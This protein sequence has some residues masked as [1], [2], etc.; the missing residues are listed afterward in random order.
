MPQRDNAEI[1]A[2]AEK[3]LQATLSLFETKV[4]QVQF[5]EEFR[6]RV[7]MDDWD[8]IARLVEQRP[9][10]VVGIQEFIEGREFINMRGVLYP[11]VMQEIIRLN[12]GS[13]VEAVLTG[14]IGTGKTTIALITTA[15]QL[16]LLA[17]YDNPQLK[18]GLDPSSEIVFIFQSITAQLAK[19][20]DY[21][22]FKAMIDNSPWFQENFR[23]DKQ[24]L[25]EL[26]FPNRI[27]CKPVSGADTAAIGQNVFGGVIDELNFMAV[28]DG[29][30]H[31]RDGGTYDQAVAVYNSISRRRKSRFMTMGKLPGI[32]NL[33]SSVRYPGQF[34]DTK[35]AESYTDI[36]RHGTTSLFV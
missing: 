3:H 27:I 29:S 30:K 31:S 20:V 35:I 9:E 12:N 34:T 5:L 17:Q 25:S 15:Y 1:L 33:V 36:E 4:E 14:A 26:H 11:V 18:F 2:L 23:Y 28:T 24:L 22:R 21:A 32:L 7:A 10:G 6:A 13:Y 19:D 16:Y 8:W